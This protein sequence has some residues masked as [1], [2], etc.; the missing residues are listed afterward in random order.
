M[1][2]RSDYCRSLA[3][4]KPDVDGVEGGYYGKCISSEQSR[5]MFDE[6]AANL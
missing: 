3:K 1:I 2:L 5:A 4:V 6:N